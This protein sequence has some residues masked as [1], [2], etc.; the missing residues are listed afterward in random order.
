MSTYCGQG[1]GTGWTVYPPL[2]G[3]EGHPGSAVDVAIFSL[4]LAGISSL[5]GAINIL[6]TI[7]NMSCIGHGWI[8]RILFVWALVVTA[9][10]LLLAIPVLGV[11]LT[12]LLFEMKIQGHA[13]GR[14]LASKTIKAFRKDVTG[15]LY[16]GN[17]IRTIT[18]T[19][20]GNGSN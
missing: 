17:C 12:L 2:S 18:G 1:A 15:H 10:L 14:I 13:L 6:V 20:L 16:G 3:P 8:K 5:A 9:G 7:R 4:H 11:A 19:N